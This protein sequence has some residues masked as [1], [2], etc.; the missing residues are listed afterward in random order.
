MSIRRDQIASRSIGLFLPIAVLAILLFGCAETPIPEAG[1]GALVQAGGVDLPA[2]KSEIQAVELRLASMAQEGEIV[3]VLAPP[4]GVLMS[5]SGGKHQW[6]G[7]TTVEYSIVPDQEAYFDQLEAEFADSTAFST[8]RELS[9]DGEDERLIVTS[10]DGTRYSVTVWTGRSK[11]Q[12]SS[13]SWCFTLQ[14]GQAEG[15]LF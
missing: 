2:L 10:S 7:S 12:V 14:P 15:G 11:V 1:N 13:S 4:N 5:C 3:G 6:T 9:P 8:K